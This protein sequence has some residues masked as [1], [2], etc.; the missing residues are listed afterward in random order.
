MSRERRWQRERRQSRYSSEQLNK[1][2]LPSVFITFTGS[3]TIEMDE[4]RLQL[5]TD[6]IMKNGCILLMMES[7]RQST[8]PNSAI[9][10]AGFYAQHHDRT[11]DSGVVEAN[12]KV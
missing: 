9:Q 11:S 7:C 5:A 8:F 6:N 10:I 12:D 2:L 4:L 3:L 1:P